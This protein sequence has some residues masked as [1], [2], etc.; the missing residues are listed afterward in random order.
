MAMEVGRDTLRVSDRMEIAVAEKKV[1]MQMNG[2]RMVLAMIA[3]LSVSQADAGWFGGS[4]EKKKEDVVM[5]PKQ[6]GKAPA[7]KAAAAPVTSATNTAGRA[8]MRRAHVHFDDAKAEQEFL[9]LTSAK[10]RV[11]EDYQVVTRLM[12]E[13]TMEAEKFTRDLETEFGIDSSVNYNYDDETMTIYEMVKKASVPADAV[14]L[15]AEKDFDKK[16][17]MKL[18]SDEKKAR[19]MRLVA[20]KKLSSDEI[21]ILRLIQNEK[22]IEASNIQ[23]QL[24]S[25]YAISNDREYRYEKSTRTLYEL[26]PVPAGTASAT[27]P[28]QEAVTK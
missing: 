20:S 28:A 21:N 11:Q 19:F 27:N 1:S 22:E 13:K 8:L 14:A 10:R 18:E 3:A 4:K 23:Q 15:D 9:A 25:R 12:Q 24:V 5:P 16:E 26:V 6:A 7:A 2:F 17:H